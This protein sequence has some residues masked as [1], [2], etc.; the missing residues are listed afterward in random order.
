M[1]LKLIIQFVTNCGKA[2]SL[3]KIF[4]TIFLLCVLCVF[5]SFALLPQTNKRVM[6]RRLTPADSRRKLTIMFNTI[7][8]AKS[9]ACPVRLRVWA[10]ARGWRTEM[11]FLRS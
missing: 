5:A 8:S 2:A 7:H 11:V 3:W 9:L 6:A 10:M 1:I 4:H